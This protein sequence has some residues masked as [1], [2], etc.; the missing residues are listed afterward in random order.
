[1]IKL[2]LKCMVMVYLYLYGWVFLYCL[3]QLVDLDDQ[4]GL[5][6]IRGSVLSVEALAVV[7][8][9]NCSWHAGTERWDYDGFN[10]IV[11]HSP[12]SVPKLN[13]K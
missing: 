5:M 11:W 12:G 1:M 3:P 9:T 4:I 8:A 13:Q 2:G 6:A 10:F 7:L